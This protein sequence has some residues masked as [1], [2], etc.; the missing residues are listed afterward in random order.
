DEIA[1]L[2]AQIAGMIRD[3]HAYINNLTQTNE[4]LDKANDTAARMSAL[5]QR[6]PLTGIRNRNGYNAEMSKLEKEIKKGGCEFGI[7]MIDL[8]YLK[9]TNDTY[10]H[11]KGNIAIKKLSNIV[12]HVFDHSPVFRIGG[13]E[14]VVVLRNDD[15]RKRETL[16]ELFMAKLQESQDDPTLEPWEK[17]SASIGIAIYEP[18]RDKGTE[19]VFKR[20]DAKMYE[21]KKEMKAARKI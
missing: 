18:A 7:A 20:A 5:A 21:N 1:T 3:I 2:S 19:T 9:V 15:Y 16:Q 11:E 14:F 17:V 8:N 12:C 4:A 6:D 13:D 10:G